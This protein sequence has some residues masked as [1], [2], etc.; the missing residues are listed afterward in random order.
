MLDIH[1]LYLVL[2]L[3]LKFSFGYSTRYQILTAN[4]RSKNKVFGPVQIPKK[5]FFEFF[6]SISR[7][8]STGTKGEKEVLFGFSTGT[9]SE[10]RRK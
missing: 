3:F 2:P 1:A 10:F 7:G 6:S 4:F 5:T 9:K 8:L